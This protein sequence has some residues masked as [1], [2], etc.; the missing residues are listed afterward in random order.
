MASRWY[1]VKLALG[2]VVLT[3][4]GA[5]AQ[6]GGATE[7]PPPQAAPQPAGPAAQQGSDVDA[8]RLGRRYPA[9]VPP[10]APRQEPQVHISVV[11]GD[12]GQAG[13]TSGS[14]SRHRLQLDG[15]GR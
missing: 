10:P 1:E 14:G 11:P 8:R 2:L 3:A 7:H 15:T 5:G 9:P 4:T 13:T 6:A 12:G